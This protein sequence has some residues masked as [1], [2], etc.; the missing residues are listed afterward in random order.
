MRENDNLFVPALWRKREIIAYS[1][2][3]YQDKS[4][5]LPAEWSK[6]KKVDLYRITLAGCVPAE[7]GVPVMNSRLVLSLGADEAVSIV[8]AGTR[9]SGKK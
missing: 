4:W 2:T 7:S 8:P 1:K 5:E 6:V 3:G 9:I